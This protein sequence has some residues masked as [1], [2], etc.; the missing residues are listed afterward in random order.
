MSIHV[1]GFEDMIGVRVIVYQVGLL[2]LM[3]G[4]VLILDIRFRGRR[5]I[6]K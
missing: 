3:I 5:M 2:I 4:L 6:L 1:F